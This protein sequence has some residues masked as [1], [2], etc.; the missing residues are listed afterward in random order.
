M[1]SGVMMMRSQTDRDA[2]SMLR[3]LAPPPGAFPQPHDDLP[4]LLVQVVGVAIALA[5][6]AVAGY[7]QLVAEGGWSWLH[8]DALLGD[9]PVVAG[10]PLLQQVIDTLWAAPVSV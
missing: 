1:R 9:S 8:L 7:A 2:E 6:V 3:R 10:R 4:G 5:G